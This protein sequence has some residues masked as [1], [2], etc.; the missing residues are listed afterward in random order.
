M[1]SFCDVSV[2]VSLSLSTVKFVPYNI[3]ISAVNMDG[4]GERAVFIN[5]TQEGSK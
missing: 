5:F 2:C 1:Y 3:F 4:E